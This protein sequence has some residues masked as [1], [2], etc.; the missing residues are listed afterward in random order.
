MTQARAGEI[1]LR[2]LRPV[3]GAT[4]QGVDEREILS[5]TRGPASSRDKSRSMSIASS[6]SPASASDS[7]R[8]LRNDGLPGVVPQTV[9][10]DLLRLAL[11][12]GEVERHAERD[13]SAVIFGMGGDG[14]AQLAYCQVR[15]VESQQHATKAEPHLRVVGR[16]A[17]AWR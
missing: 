17:T 4:G 14:G 10:I 13:V 12:A 15:P 3:F 8:L 2:H 7:A 16:Q 5:D 1:S 11:I 6:S 9:T